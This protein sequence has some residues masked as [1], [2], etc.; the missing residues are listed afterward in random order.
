VLRAPPRTLLSYLLKKLGLILDTTHTTKSPIHPPIIGGD[1][2]KV[3]FREE[4]GQQCAE[5][6]YLVDEGWGKAAA[7]C[8]E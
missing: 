8:L 1:M 4:I 7:G 3:G 2:T 5:A 6:F